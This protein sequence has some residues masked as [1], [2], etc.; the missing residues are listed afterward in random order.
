MAAIQII[1]QDFTPSSSDPTLCDEEKGPNTAPIQPRHDLSTW[2]WIL[3]LIGLYIG[4]L[5]YGLMVTR[6][7]HILPLRDLPC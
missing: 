6:I 4:A 1:S 5:L 2:Q 7:T 3:T